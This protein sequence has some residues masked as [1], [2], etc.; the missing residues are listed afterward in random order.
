MTTHKNI[1]DVAD[2][3]AKEYLSVNAI[4]KDKDGAPSTVCFL[5]QQMAEKVCV[6]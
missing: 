1:Q 2:R 4:L 3:I 6:I 5:S